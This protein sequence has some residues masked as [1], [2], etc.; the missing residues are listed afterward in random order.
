METPELKISFFFT[1]NVDHTPDPCKNVWSGG[2][3]TFLIRVRP[4]ICVSFS[5]NP[6][7]VT[8]WVE[9]SCFDKL[10]CQTRPFLWWRAKPPRGCMGCAPSGVFYVQFFVVNIGVKEISDNA[11]TLQCATNV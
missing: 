5:A 3:S 10:S 1:E 8:E 9:R 7:E 4:V 6:P 2:W 11:T